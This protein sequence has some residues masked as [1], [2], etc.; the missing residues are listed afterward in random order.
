M[1]ADETSERIKRAALA[2]FVEVGYG[3]TTVD[4]IAAGAGVGV[5]SLYRRW[6]DKAALANELVVDYLEAVDAILAPIGGGTRRSRFL[7]LWD[8]MW[9][10][11]QADPDL[12]LFVEAQASAGFLT[13]DVAVRKADMGDRW[14][15][16]MGDFGIRA[17]PVAAASMLVGTVTAVWRGGLQVDPDDLGE[18]LWAALRTE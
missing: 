5:A 7:T 11:A 18:R 17:D 15:D 9:Q 16:A 3:S 12:L 2:R 14:M 8:R 13:D 4:E 6:P 1:S 10:Q